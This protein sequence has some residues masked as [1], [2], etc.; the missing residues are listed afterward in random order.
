M[1]QSL[2]SL[3]LNVNKTWFD[4]VQSGIKTE[5]YRAYND[6][7]KKRLIN[8][9]GSPRSF[10]DIQ[11]KLG[12]PKSG[13]ASRLM[14]FMWCGY[15]VKTIVHPHFNNEPQKVFAIKLNKL[16]GGSNVKS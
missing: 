11:Y 1:R 7:W 16:V 2:P 15:E 6:Y 4:E 3:I 5:E 13:D 14:T 8:P 12:Y 10:K 9:D